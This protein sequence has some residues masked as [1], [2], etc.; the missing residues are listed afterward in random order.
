LHYKKIDIFSM[1]NNINFF[2]PFWSI[3]FIHYISSFLIVSL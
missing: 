1:S 2:H 3:A